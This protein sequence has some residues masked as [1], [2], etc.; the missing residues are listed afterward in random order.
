MSASD[1]A[2]LTRS[3]QF[4]MHEMGKC[5]KRETKERWTRDVAE[6]PFDLIRNRAL[7]EGRAEHFLE[8]LKQAQHS[9]LN[10]G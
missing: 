3:W 4:V 9:L 7:I 8:V 2:A 5:K 6:Q 1:P 10:G